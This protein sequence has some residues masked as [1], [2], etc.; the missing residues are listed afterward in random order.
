MNELGSE[1]GKI[2]NPFLPLTLTYTNI[3]RVDEIGG[4][5]S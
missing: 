2:S 4:I 3:S 1:M 5:W